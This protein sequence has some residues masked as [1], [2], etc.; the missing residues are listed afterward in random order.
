MEDFHGNGSRKRGLNLEFISDRGAKRKSQI[1]FG[2]L[3]CNSPAFETNEKRQLKA[4][5]RLK[6]SE[7]M[8][9][10]TLKPKDALKSAPQIYVYDECHD[11]NH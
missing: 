5:D 6:T 10:N 8:R 11:R 1:K 2:D 9:L 4:V 7:A 3:S